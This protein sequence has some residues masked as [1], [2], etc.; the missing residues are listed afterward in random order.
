MFGY[1]VIRIDFEWID[2]VKLILVKIELK[3]K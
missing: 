3:V 2:N 1:V